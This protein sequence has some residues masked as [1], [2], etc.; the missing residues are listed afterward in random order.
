MSKRLSIIFCSLL[1]IGVAI[2]PLRLLAAN[3][4]GIESTV[5]AVN[6][7]ENLLPRKVAGAGSVPQLIGKGV[8]LILSVLAIVFFLLIFYSGIIW[9]TARGNNE[10][11][12]Q[13]KAGLESAVVGVIIVVFAYAISSFVFKQLAG[14]NSPGASC[15][16]DS[17]C[18]AGETC[19]ATYS[20]C[21]KK[22]GSGF[23]P[24]TGK[25]CQSQSDCAAGQACD[26]A[27]SQCRQGRSVHRCVVQSNRQVLTVAGVI[28][29]T[30]MTDGQCQEG[31]KCELITE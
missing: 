11:V 16:S 30:C 14:G 13:A 2:F 24:A 20:A 31:E 19:D 8:T 21:L 23:V 25:T 22:A 26:P 27:T 6:G 28:S 9:M 17:D 15:K 3:Y 1:F 29:D 7:K 5:D 4:Y 18:A 10:L 12:N